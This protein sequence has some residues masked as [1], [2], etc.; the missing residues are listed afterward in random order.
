MRVGKPDR[1]TGRMVK[2]EVAD[3]VDYIESLPATPEVMLLVD[4][5]IDRQRTASEL[6]RVYQQDLP[7][8]SSMMLL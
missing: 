1:R 8:S 7:F 6:A 3:V 2:D 4:I 5:N